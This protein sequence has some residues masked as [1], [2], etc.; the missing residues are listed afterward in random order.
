MPGKALAVSR[1]EG[2]QPTAPGQ[3]SQPRPGRNERESEQLTD[4]Y[5][6]E[7][8]CLEYQHHHDA[9]NAQ[10]TH[11][12]VRQHSKE[13]LLVAMR[14]RQRIGQ[15][16]E[17]VQVQC[18]GRPHP[19]EQ[20]DRSGQGGIAVS[21][22]VNGHADQRPLNRLE[23]EYQAEGKTD[24]FAA[25]KQTLLGVRESQPY[26]DLAER[27]GMNES[28]VKVAVHRL[29]KRYRELIRAEIANTLDRSQN[30]ETEMRYLFQVLS[31]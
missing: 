21:A 10:C 18:A 12:R 15:V 3:R 13:L 16:S 9:D 27:L 14:S 5:L 31:E 17:A 28:A 29:R 1:F 11:V 8:R 26:A 7:A 25:L 19:D 22:N 30:V 4:G 6:G 2:L 20:P 24:L 23:G